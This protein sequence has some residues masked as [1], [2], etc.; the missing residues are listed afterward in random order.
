VEVPIQL[1]IHEGMTYVTSR[2]PLLRDAQDHARERGDTVVS[3]LRVAHH[4]DRGVLSAAD[5]LHASLLVMGWKGYTT[6][7]E[8]IFGEIMDR[9]VKRVRCDVA[10]VKL[11]ES[12]RFERI[13]LPTAGGPHAEFA[14]ELI[15]PI[16]R[17]YGSRVTACYIIPEEADERQEQEAHQWI[18]RTLRHVDL[19]DVEQLVIRSRSVPHGIAR[20]GDSHDLIVMGAAQTG[21]FQ[22]LLFGEVPDRVSRLAT[23]SVMLVKRRERPAKAW[24]RRLI[25]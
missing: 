2:M 1:P 23:T 9:V 13:L 7:R 14:A 22:Q 5:D 8:R 18:G 20:A 6:K 17:A 10:V 19:G 12:P 16:A 25:S 3:D 4:V 21:L 11:M 24:I 15:Q